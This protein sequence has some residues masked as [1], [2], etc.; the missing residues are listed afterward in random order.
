MSV[1]GPGARGKGGGESG[2]GPPRRQ[3]A[4]LS[5]LVPPRAD[6]KLPQER[7]RAGDAGQRGRGGGGAMESAAKGSYVLANLAEVVERVL[8][9]LPTKA[10]LRAAW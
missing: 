6:R 8:G 7:R 1:L 9:F 3:A 5:W 2:T 4:P 10:L